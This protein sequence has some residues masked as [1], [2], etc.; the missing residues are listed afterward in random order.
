[1]FK[2]IN[3]FN[4]STFLG[5]TPMPRLKKPID[6]IEELCSSPIRRK[7]M[8]GHR[9][10]ELYTEW[11]EN[12]EPTPFLRFMKYIQQN[13]EEIGVAQFFGKFRAFSFE[14]YI[15][16]LLRREVYIYKPLN[17][18]WG[19][20]SVV[21]IERDGA[22]GVEVDI[23]IGTAIDALVLPKIVVETKVELDASR[24]K[25]ALASFMLIKACNKKARC[26]LVYIKQ[27]VN[28][29][30][31]SLAEKWI[32]GTFRFDVGKEEEV[33]K[34]IEVIKEVLKRES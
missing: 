31:L 10:K 28:P 2:V 24:L 29:I 25:T 6:Y 22:Y 21:S 4:P 30:L 9:L 23:A 15:Y 26:F 18:F 1:M 34:F 17:V 5:S 33:L 13:K 12:L 16:R 27:E 32:D 20:R 11:V 3:A 14:E 8:I 19:K 7:R